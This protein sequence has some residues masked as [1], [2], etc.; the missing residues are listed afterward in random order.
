MACNRR[1]FGGRPD[2]RVGSEMKIAPRFYGTSRFKSHIKLYD[3][4]RDNPNYFMCDA[5]FAREP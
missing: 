3:S 1:R 2:V 4:A 5:D